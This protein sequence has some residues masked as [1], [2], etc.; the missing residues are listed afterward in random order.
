[1]GEGKAKRP[2]PFEEKRIPLRVLKNN[3]AGNRKKNKRGKR[4]LVQGYRRRTNFN[5]HINDLFCFHPNANKTLER[6]SQNFRERG[7]GT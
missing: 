7:A 1:M 3:T 5:F 2:G 4:D 6:L